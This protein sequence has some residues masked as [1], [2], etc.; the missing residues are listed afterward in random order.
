MTMLDGIRVLSFNHFLLGPMGMQVLGDLGA[1]VIAVEPVG[2]GFQRKWSGANRRA[3]GESLLHLCA[4]RNK[5]NIAIDLKSAEG[6]EIVHRLIAKSDVI[7]ENFR[8]GVMDKFGFGYENAKAINAGVIYASASGYGG[9]GPYR[10]RPGQDLVVQAMSGLAMINGNDQQAPVPVGVSA[11]DHHGAQILAMAILAALVRRGRTGEGCRVEVDLLSAGLDMQ[12]ESL[13]CWAN[14]EPVSLRPPANIAGWYFSAPYG[15]YETADGH[16]AISLGA[17]EALATALD[18]P[19]LAKFSDAETFSRNREIAALIQAQVAG[20]SSDEIEAKLEAQSLWY[21][22]VNDYAAVMTD[23]QV[24]HNGSFMTVDGA[25]GEPIILLGHPARYDG[26][27][28]GVRRPPQ[29]IGAQ[30]AEVLGEIG[31]DDAA[32]AAMAE[33][34][35][36]AVASS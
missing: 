8:P 1:D 18:L 15:I 27:R 11:I 19:A 9:D 23:P 7:C 20:W 35:S 33:T 25:N 21:A 14:G 36:I 24:V 5:R 6:K 29:P 13:V 17:M 30:T 32:I 16:M 2:G 10:E 34:S 22:R 28:P 31:Y 4:N 12:C 26:E 3:D